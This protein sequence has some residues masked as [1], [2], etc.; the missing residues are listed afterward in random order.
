MDGSTIELQLEE[1]Q[2]DSA[3]LRG[4][5]KKAVVVMPLDEVKAVW[6]RRVRPRRA[7]AVYLA[8][9]GAAELFAVLFAKPPV[10]IVTLAMIGVLLGGP[11][12]AGAWIVLKRLKLFQ[13]WVLIYDRADGA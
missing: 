4:R 12:C 9:L 2:L 7:A 8:I 1:V 5:H 13:E 3:E 10:S 11:L 6:V